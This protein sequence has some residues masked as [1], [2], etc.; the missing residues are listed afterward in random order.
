MQLIQVHSKRGER[1]GGWLTW[2]I[3][4]KAFSISEGK[5]DVNFESLKFKVKGVTQD[6]SLCQNINMNREIRYNKE[7]EELCYHFLAY[8][9][10]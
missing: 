3:E 6:D 2:K 8:R 4:K 7:R 5:L 10:T 9:V 1:T